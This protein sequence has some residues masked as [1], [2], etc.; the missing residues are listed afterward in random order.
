MCKLRVINVQVFLL[1]M[2]ERLRMYGK[3]CVSMIAMCTYVCV[4][5]CVRMCISTVVLCK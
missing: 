2:W 5:M 3:G 1:I 4:S